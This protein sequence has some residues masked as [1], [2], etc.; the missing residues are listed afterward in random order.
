M[1]VY[2][3]CCGTCDISFFGLFPGIAVASRELINFH[4]V[5]RYANTGGLSLYR[6]CS[7]LHVLKLVFPVC[8]LVYYLLQDNKYQ[9]IRNSSVTYEYIRCIDVHFVQ[10]NRFVSSRKTVFVAQKLTHSSWLRLLVR[11]SSIS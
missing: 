9:S 4:R 7:I 11:T 10:H 3:T 2:L 8:V 1:F 5:F 6:L